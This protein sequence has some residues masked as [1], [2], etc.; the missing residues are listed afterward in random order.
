MIIG[1]S[2]VLLYYID[3]HMSP[4]LLLDNFATVAEAVGGLQKLS[5]GIIHQHLC[6]GV[7]VTDG[8]GGFHLTKMFTFT[9]LLHCLPNVP[10]NLDF[11]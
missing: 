11:C 9:V 5:L 4:S 10:D 7:E 6:H 3:I 8:Q 2:R 1:V